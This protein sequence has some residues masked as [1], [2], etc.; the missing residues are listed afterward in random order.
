MMWPNPIGPE[1]IRFY[2]L[3]GIGFSAVKRATF[4]W[5]HFWSFLVRKVGHFVGDVTLILERAQAGDH[6]AARLIM[7]KAFTRESDEPNAD[8][9][10]TSRPPL[11]PGSR[12]YMTREGAER[13]RVRL[14]GLLETKQGLAAKSDDATTAQTEQRKLESAIRNLQ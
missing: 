10:P 9:T 14:K 13:L 1:P 5:F 11:P 2:R 12:N 6:K 3:L 7:S 4:S 8:E